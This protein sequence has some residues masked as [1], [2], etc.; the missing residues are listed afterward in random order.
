MR[1]ELLLRTSAYPRA[2][3][4]IGHALGVRQGEQRLIGLMLLH[5][6]GVGI[7]RVFSYAAT[8]ALF[9]S[10]Y[11]ASKLPYVYVAA[12]V[13]TSFFSIAYGWLG[14]RVRFRRLLA[15][16]LGFTLGMFLILRGLL[17]FT[18]AAWPT[19]VGAVWT[20]LLW[21]LVHLEFWGL[22]GRLLD[23]RQAKRLFG[24]MG[25]GETTATIL[26]GLALAPL[27]GVIGTP[28]LLLVA[29]VG[30]ACSLLAFNR[31]TAAYGA[32]LEATGERGDEGD[33]GTA[34]RERA[35]SL[36]S[37]L[38]VR[39]LCSAVALSVT[40]FFF[41]DMAFLTESSR[42]FPDVDRL[43]AFLGPFAAAANA[44][45]FLVRAFLTGPVLSRYGITAG[46]LALPV[47][48]GLGSA[49][50]VGAGALGGSAW[51]IFVFMA[52]T[53]LIDG[54]LR[55]SIDSSTVLLLYQP[56]SPRN[57]T[58]T[59]A[60]VEGLVSPLAGGA[61]GIIIL[62]LQR[63]MGLGTI[64]LASFVLS[65]A[66]AWVAM[67][68]ALRSSYLKVLV[69]ALGRRRLRAED[70]S[71]T[72]GHTVAAVRHGLRSTHP[73]EVIY[74]LGILEG[75]DP[76]RHRAAL[77][78]LLTHPSPLVR[79]DVVERVERLSLTDLVEAVRSLAHADPD[80]GVRGV[81]VRTLCA[82]GE[83]DVI[84]EVV[85]LLDDLNPEVRMG[86]MVGLL[87]NGGIEGVM[88]AAVCLRTWVTS[89]DPRD[90]A[91]AARVLGAAGIRGFHRPLLP[92]LDDPAAPVRR[93]ALRAAGLIPHR[94]EWPPIVALLGHPML[95]TNAA[96]ALA[97]G[98]EEV[99]DLL[100]PALSA[101]EGA[102]ANR[103]GAADVLGL[104][105][106]PRATALLA[107]QL[108]DQDTG[109]RSAVDR[110]LAKCGWR[111]AASAERQA[112]RTA[113]DQEVAWAAWFLAAIVD[114][115][116]SY[117]VVVSGLEHALAGVRVRVLSL[118]SF[119]YP[120]A[121]EVAAMLTAER[122][123]GERRAYA[124]EAL[125]SVLPIELKTVV[126]PLFEDTSARRCLQRLS[127][128]HPQES[129][130]A[131]R[132]LE[133]LIAE[134]PAWVTPWIRACAVHTAGAMRLVSCAPAVE[135]ARACREP[136]VQQTAAW[137]A[138]VLGPEITPRTTIGGRQ[139]FPTIERI[140]ILKS[141][142]IF[143]EVPDE[144]LVPLAGI[145]SEVEI[146]KGDPVFAKGDSGTSMFVVVEGKVRIHDG[147]RTLRELGPREVFGELSALDP[148]PRSASVT[149]LVDTLLFRVDQEPL[150]ELLT[151]Q[152]GMVRGVIR[153]LARL[154][155]N[156]PSG[157]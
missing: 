73:H 41:I 115:G 13:V 77:G 49:G 27:V 44:G 50:V 35:A 85:P 87:R 10:R 28:N 70:L 55:E 142:D 68:L 151:G 36:I 152:P 96:T 20:E 75:I 63:F 21:A 8:S 157:P 45:V 37:G 98:G 1:W 86:A 92:L 138:A 88:A 137:A 17:A 116:D 123:A 40:A 114:L 52:A 76:T 31:L 101:R 89:A 60:M 126:L 23:V 26:G 12:A 43:A 146:R 38:Y 154:V 131:E 16:N 105:G 106:G 57:R 120:V 74:C 129:L 46:L 81:A 91:F 25:A 47:L 2:G 32:H 14:G 133:G 145:V 135:T 104:I 121:P 127:L 136:L 51:I 39:L 139:M 93:E 117:R 94:R 83:E 140:L 29:A 69:E 122:A 148:E 110:S 64:R 150:L 67:A 147:D 65:I 97:A 42:R 84:D 107:A 103:A 102:S 141:A 3:F 30:T 144:Q 11:D 18:D 153:T 118:V 80:A 24:L 143:S 62:L 149:A 15:A 6:M 56:L 111:P 156:R 134:P 34:P 124:L 79:R 95:G 48:V 66:F 61:A 128:I 112:V 109:V 22:A 71:F 113:L 9:L 125:D 82:L 132:R 7:T 78:E 72:D 108:D 58:R 53:R 119:L 33:G 90:R 100:E 99:V 155:R 4:Q 59:M 19:L 54:A 5:S 130:P